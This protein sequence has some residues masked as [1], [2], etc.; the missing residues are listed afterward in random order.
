MLYVMNVCSKKV[1]C[2]SICV[3]CIRILSQ[4]TVGFVEQPLTG[5]VC[6][7]LG[8]CYADIPYVWESCSMLCWSIRAQTAVRAC[9]L[10]L[11]TE[12]AHCGCFLFKPSSLLYV[13]TNPLKKACREH[14]Y[15][16]VCTV[17]L[18]VSYWPLW[19]I[20]MHFQ[21]SW[22]WDGL[23]CECF[24]VFITWRQ[25]VN[26]F[27]LWNYCSL[28]EMCV[29]VLAHVLGWTCVGGGSCEL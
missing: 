23:M 6:H 10:Q 5:P 24:Y 4:P 8:V 27:N 11:F 9:C 29:F 25:Y 3:H 15:L 16:T 12:A 22:V 7:W 14:P 26:L 20:R 18:S 2:T 28:G 1:T 17:Y 21:C 19:Q 13:S